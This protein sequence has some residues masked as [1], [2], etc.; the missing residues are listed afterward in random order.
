MADAHKGFKMRNIMTG[1]STIAIL[2]AAAVL[3]ACTS[4]PES[5]NQTAYFDNFVYEGDDAT[6]KAKPPPDER[7]CYTPILQRWASVPSAC[8]HS[9][10]DYYHPTPTFV[11]FPGVPI[12]HS[13][14]LVNWRQIGYVLDRES[15]LRN[16][17]GQ[18]VSG[19]IFAPAISYNPHN[20]TYYMVTTNVGAGNFFVKA[21][22]PAGPWS[23]PIMLPE[24]GGIDPSFFFDEDG[25]AYIVNNDE[26]SYPAEYP[27][28]RSIR[29]REF[30]VATDR[31]VGDWKVLVD[32]GVNPAEKP[33]WIE[34]PHMY[35]ING[36][37][38]LM[39]AEGGTSTWHS[40][41]IF[42]SDSPWGPFVP[43]EHNPILTQRHLDPNRPDPV[44]CAGHADLIQAKEGDWW[45]VFLA[46][47]PID[48][49]FENL[50]RE[51]FILPVG[52]PGDGLPVILAGVGTGALRGR[53]GAATP[54]PDKLQGNYGYRTDFDEPQLGFEWMSLRKGLGSLCSLTEEPGYLALRCS[55]A[56]ASE[57]RTPAMCCYRMQHHKFTASTDVVFDASTPD[58]AAG[59]L[60]FKDEN[61]HYFF[62]ISGI[63]AE[64]S[65]SVLKF[66]NMGRSET[67]ATAPLARGKVRLKVVS[68]GLTY[69]FAYSVDG[70]KE[71]TLCSG[72][73]AD[74]L[75]TAV[76]GGFTGSVIG[77]YAVR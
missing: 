31:T 66:G 55:D 27:G 56:K 43:Y 11:Y 75:S 36:R 28:H 5:G 38:F 60:L 34:G 16:T 24:V 46:C 74:Y 1:K 4:L 18:H 32:K 22:D 48:G 40:E 62:A 39:D 50:G 17:E 10:G 69:G 70:G 68:D 54:A 33:I 30:D 35:K 2:G 6:Y 44:T 73:E 26:P 63:G 20:K 45:A 61:H 42:A 7:S 71:S 19:G 25:R 14:D 65:I 8:T 77:L 29:I 9:E 59:M 64:R 23:E 15:Q 52:W 37:Y 3:A 41:V 13:R 72:V 21:T 76:A 47:R 49:R 51:T 58:E 12:Y 53:G 67:L 57:R